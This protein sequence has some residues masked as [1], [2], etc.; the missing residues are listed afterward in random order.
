M[1]RK[2]VIGKFGLSS[3]TTLLVEPFMNWG[4]DFISP[5]KL[6]SRTTRNQYILVATN[7][8]TKWVEAKVLR[9]NTTT[10]IAKFLYE[11]IL[12]T[13][14]CPLTLVS[15]QGVHF[16]NATIKMLSTHFLMKHISSTTYYLQGNG[17][18]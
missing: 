16:I 6:A 4:I 14:N 10:V 17:Q 1:D 13:F 2:S 15:D 18:A 3:C 7:Y 9:T 12:T 5:I 8:A 11:N